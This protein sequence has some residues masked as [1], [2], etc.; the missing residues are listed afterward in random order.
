MPAT[1]PGSLALDVDGTLLTSTDE[2]T[3]RTRRASPKPRARHVALVTGRPLPIALTVVHDL[4]LGRLVAANGAT[5][6]D[7][8]TGTV[9]YQ[10]SLRR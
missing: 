10:A 6:A 3:D 8:T 7:T 5:V 2:L 1:C 4:G 9:L